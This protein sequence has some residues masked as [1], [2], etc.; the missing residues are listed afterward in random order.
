MNTIEILSKLESVNFTTEQART[1]T[2]IVEDRQH[3]LATK[4]DLKTNIASV[5]DDLKTSIASVRSDLKTSITSVREDLKVSTASVR[6][7]MKTN[8]ASVR[9]EMKVMESQL[10]SE[11]LSAKYDLVKWIVGG[12]V[13]NGLV[14][15]LLKYFG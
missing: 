12:L 1:I 2:E 11:I 3:Q 9:D 7:E 5:K 10:R 8:I 4:D 6:N 15:A 14:N 13:A